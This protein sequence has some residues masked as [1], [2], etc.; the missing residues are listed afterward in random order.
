MPKVARRVGCGLGALKVTLKTDNADD[1]DVDAATFAAGEVPEH[2]TVPNAEAWGATL[3]ARQSD[4][5][6]VICPGA[7]YATNG[8][9][10]TGDAVSQKLT[11]GYS[12]HMSI[13]KS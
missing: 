4:G 11:P 5:R 2:Q 7:T 12:N 10:T 8:M 3:A 6:Q 9:A 13:S 1:F